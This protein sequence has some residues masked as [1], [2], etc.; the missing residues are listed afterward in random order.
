MNHEEFK[1]NLAND[2]KSR[3]SQNMALR[4]QLKPEWRLRTYFISMV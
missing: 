4:S 3:W 2:V 1:E